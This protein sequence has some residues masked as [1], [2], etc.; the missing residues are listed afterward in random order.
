MKYN[1]QRGVALVITLLMLSV[2]TFMAITFL[3]LSRRERATLSV[4]KSQTDAQ[5]M[6]ETALDR[7]TAEIVSR[8][9]AKTNLQDY[10]LMV[11]TNFINP[12]G[13]DPSLP[14]GPRQLTNVNYSFRTS[15]Q[16]LTKNDL[17]QNLTNLFFNPRPP[18]FI[19][20]NENTGEEDFR[21]WF[22]MNRNRWFDTN[23]MQFVLDRFG[24][25]IIDPDTGG[26]ISNSFIGDPEWI[27]VLEDPT[28]T[29]SPNNL[30]VGR[31]A[32]I[33]VPE[34]NCLDFNANHNQAKRPSSVGSDGFM[35][36]Q[37]VGSW[38][39]NL[40]AFLHTLNTN[41]WPGYNFNAAS[42][43][44]SSSGESF[45]DALAFLRYRYNDSYINL[46]SFTDLFG[47]DAASAFENDGI[48]GYTD[49][50]LMITDV[51][52]NLD[53]PET[54]PVETPWPGADNPRRFTDIQDVF[55]AFR[56]E[57]SMGNFRN[58][59]LSAGE[60]PS[61]Y[62]GNTFYR[63]LGQIGVDSKPDVEGKININYAN[64]ASDYPTESVDW[65]P[66][67]FF[68]NAADRLLRTHFNFGI[69]NI[70]VYPTNNY[71]ASVHRLLQVTANVFDST[72]NRIDL[73]NEPYLPSVFKPIFN[74]NGTNI[75]IAGYEEITNL[76][77]LNRPWRDLSIRADRNALQPRDNVYG[78]PMVIGAKKG[79]PNLNELT[80]Q[81][82][83][84]MTRKLELRRPNQT[85]LPNET[86]QMYVVGISNL[87]GVESWNSY[88]Q[89]FPRPLQIRVTN[90]FTMVLSNLPSPPF[91]QT[92]QP[93]LITNQT[94]GAV[95]NIAANQ[96][97]GWLG[98]QISD[99]LITPL[100]TN[101]VFVPD[102]AYRELQPPH[103]IPLG[104]P[105]STNFERRAGFYVPN[106]SLHITN[107]FTYMMFD[108]TTGR[109]IDYASFDNLAAQM[110]L[111]RELM[112]RRTIGGETS[113]IGNMWSTNRTGANGN[114][115]RRT[116]TEGIINQLQVS[117]GNDQV[118]QSVWTSYNQDT[119]T[120]QDKD[121][122]ID[123][124]RVFTGLS[125]L[126]YPRHQLQFS[127]R[128]MQAPFTPSRKLIKTYSLQVNDPLV[129]YTIEDLYDLTQT[130]N[131]QFASPP[132]SYPADI[133]N[134]GKVNPRFSPWGGNPFKADSDV[135]NF[136]VGFKDPSVTQSSDWRFPTN[137]FPN[138][139][140]LGRVHR[141]TPWQ[142]IYLKPWMPQFAT[143][144]YWLTWAG[145][146]FTNP[147]ND[148]RILNVFT[149]A[150]NENMAK[151]RL[152]INQTNLAAW[153]AVLGG[154]TVL[155]NKP[156]GLEPEPLVIHPNSPQMH[157]IL[158]NINT[159]RA[160]RHHGAFQHLGEVLDAP[161]LTIDSPYL[162]QAADGITDEM[163]ERIPQ[164]ILSLL[165]LDKPRITV[166][167][168]GQ[169]LDPAEN[170]YVLTPGD[171][172]KL[173]T[174][175]QISGEVITKSVIRIEGDPEKPRAVIEDFDVIQGE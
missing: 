16:P 88:T 28:R 143:N 68:T 128:S 104:Y 41:Y 46:D 103:F 156:A 76:A 49:G 132:Q 111:T 166:Y 152:G 51:M 154:V 42:L 17:F 23:G 120:G 85:M 66:V 122:A 96:W 172:Y 54:D 80:F 29:H 97:P 106:W 137:K 173:C 69:T 171:F 2:V 167:A 43:N 45:Q 22:D 1:S 159:T 48:D 165:K 53:I 33:T 35:R 77:F 81:S 131:V 31:F 110:N 30:F 100:R 136:N 27:G 94:I 6:A 18:V 55:T 102:A 56:T 78:I 57:S 109:L 157:Q 15:G 92:A 40:A 133:V 14:P 158:E 60:Q 108:Q 170:S 115:G 107:R 58:R 146:E 151:G 117:L 7:A 83:V 75:Y 59:L 24:K 142:T 20:T 64:L 150:L 4:V 3:A 161:A 121:K 10:D 144:A 118:S 149:T 65:R 129:H 95:T 99:S 86:N 124:F 37:G 175:Y 153:S 74:K 47:S 160:Q 164:R 21:F 125:P 73:S 71:S 36:N 19:T 112:G 82:I 155:S 63:M 52:Q 98:E 8:M 62:N 72:T 127:G 38:E 139:G 5:L 116:P 162:N 39:I 174:N 25:P 11:S 79:F 70:S 135:R 148:W 91:N 145:N 130:N 84:Q 138:I 126:A 50:P 123:K 90:T 13:F 89:A 67:Q 113:E 119:I 26:Y 105:T 93:L 163:M 9:I 32:Y 101:F 141:G 44:N 87:F 12:R 147:T 114:Y 34:G 134:L 140:W 61:T 168:I 169:S